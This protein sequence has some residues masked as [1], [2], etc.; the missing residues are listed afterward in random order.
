MFDYLLLHLLVVAQAAPDL[1]QSIVLPT[2]LL[3]VGVFSSSSFEWVQ[4]KW[5]WLNTT[6]PLVRFVASGLWAGLAGFLALKLGQNVPTDI[7]S[8]DVGSWA[9]FLT[10]LAAW[11]WHALVKSYRATVAS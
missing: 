11:A 10:S 5:A 7:A 8:F 2:I 1:L 6:Y 9:A 3:V 4:A